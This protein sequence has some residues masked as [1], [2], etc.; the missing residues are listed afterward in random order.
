MNIYSKLL[1]ITMFSFLSSIPAS[2]EE[3]RVMIETPPKAKEIFRYKA[4]I[5]ALAEFMDD[6]N[7]SC[8]LRKEAVDT[9][10]HWLAVNKDAPLAWTCF[11]CPYPNDPNRM[12]NCIYN[13]CPN[14]PSSP[15]PPVPLSQ[16]V[17]CCMSVCR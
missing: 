6:A 10:D 7:A 8:D 4:A 15:S 13:Y 12:K 9:L 3:D 16:C 11:R 14:Q 1:I 5:D 17:A 2:A